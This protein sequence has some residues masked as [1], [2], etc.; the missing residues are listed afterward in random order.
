MNKLLNRLVEDLEVLGGN[1]EV[2]WCREG[3][4][5]DLSLLLFL[6]SGDVSLD[7]AGF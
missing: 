2:I 3:C 1:A 7:T 4:E 6:V 5:A